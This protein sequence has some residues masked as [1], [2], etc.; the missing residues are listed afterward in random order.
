LKKR[1]YII[2]L[3]GII[4]WNYSF[5]DVSP[6]ADVMAAIALSIFSINLK[7]VIK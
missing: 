6:L 1:I 3:V 4:A 2:W 5:P 7:R